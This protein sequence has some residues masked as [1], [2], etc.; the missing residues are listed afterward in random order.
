MPRIIAT[1]SAAFTQLF[2][3]VYVALMWCE[4]N[5]FNLKGARLNLLIAYRN[6]LVFQFQLDTLFQMLL[7]LAIDLAACVWSWSQADGLGL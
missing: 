2:F 4:A 7:P 5:S 6:A 1:A 3:C